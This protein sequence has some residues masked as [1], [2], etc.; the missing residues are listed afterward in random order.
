MCQ[1]QI[2]NME[3]KESAKVAALPFFRCNKSNNEK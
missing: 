1:I 3:L 2:R